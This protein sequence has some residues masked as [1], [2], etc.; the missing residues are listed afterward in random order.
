MVK[1]L[2][3]D[4]PRGPLFFSWFFPQ[5]K[6]PVDKG[7]VGRLSGNPDQSTRKAGAAP[8]KRL[9][10]SGIGGTLRLHWKNLRGD[11]ESKSTPSCLP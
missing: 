6:S 4:G 9:Q 2:S 7:K 8:E 11:V 1:A 3:G 5:S 10:G